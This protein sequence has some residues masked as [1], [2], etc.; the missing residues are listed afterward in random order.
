M[1]LSTVVSELRIYRNSRLEALIA[2]YQPYSEVRL[3]RQQLTDVDIDIIVQQVI[4]NKRCK[5]LTLAFNEITPK[6]ASILADA[7]YSNTTLYELWLSTN[8]VSDAGVCYLAQAL[9][10]NQTLKKLGLAS[11]DITNAG[12]SHLVEMLK[13]N[14]TLNTL[15]LAMNKIDDQG[16]QMLANALAQQN[17]N[18][19]VLTLD[20]NRLVSDFSVNA[21]INMIKHSRSLKELWVNDCS[22]SEKGKKKLQEVTESN[23]AFKLVTM[24]AKSS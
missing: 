1:I 8:H 16:V 22:L 7:M 21:L 4:I 3:N 23:K 20:R 15:G 9:S 14:K 19:E 17:T 2:E 10:V 13:K 12:V 11:N 5:S 24:Y 6:G 18:L